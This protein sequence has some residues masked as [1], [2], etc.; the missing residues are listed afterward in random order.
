LLFGYTIIIHKSKYKVNQK[1]ANRSC[2]KV[3][4]GKI[5]PCFFATSVL[6][7]GLGENVSDVGG[8]VYG[9]ISLTY[10]GSY[11]EDS[12]HTLKVHEV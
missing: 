8:A 11:T 9:P 10:C 2:Y 6:I 1:S 7:C 4:L 3:I 12:L 5:N